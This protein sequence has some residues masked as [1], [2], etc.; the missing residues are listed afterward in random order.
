MKQTKIESLIESCINVASGFLLALVIWQTIA[1]YFLG[2]EITL[3]ENIF[4]TSIFTV[5][6]ITRGYIWRR[7]FNAGIHK[8]IH[9]WVTK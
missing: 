1:P 5:V 9:R 4:L 8:A 6:G 7:F 3:S 2:Y